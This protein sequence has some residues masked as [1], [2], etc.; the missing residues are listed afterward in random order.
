LT[1]LTARE[2]DRREKEEHT[3]KTKTLPKTPPETLPKTQAA[4]LVELEIQRVSDHFADVS[5]TIDMPV[6]KNE[7]K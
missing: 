7:N 6:K 3:V 2:V 4:I 1:Q 5:K